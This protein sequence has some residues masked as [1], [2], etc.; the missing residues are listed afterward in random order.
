VSDRFDLYQFRARVQPATLVALPLAVT[1]AAVFG[2]QRDVASGLIAF[3]GA[4]GVLYFVAH[5]VR[6]RGGRLEP[7]LWASWG[8]APTSQVLRGSSGRGSDE[9][10]RRRWSVMRRLMPES[11]ISE[12]PPSESEIEIYVGILRER[13]RSADAFPRVA[14]ENAGYGFRRNMLGLRLLGLLGSGVALAVVLAVLISRLVSGDGH[15]DAILAL[16]AVFDIL[17][18][19]AWCFVVK[20]DWVKEQ[21]F[22]YAEALLGAAESLAPSPT[23]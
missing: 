20:A 22:H 18:I 2:A 3:A 21:G 7:S 4:A 14:A 1:L 16:V 6:D 23:S 19:T 13:T 9:L 8:G 5:L 15:G 10:D 17:C 11:A 12:G